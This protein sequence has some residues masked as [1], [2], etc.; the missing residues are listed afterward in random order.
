LKIK[1]KKRDKQNPAEPSGPPSFEELFKATGGARLGMRARADQQ[2]K[3]I[4]TEQIDPSITGNNIPEITLLNVEI[5][6]NNLEII[7]KEKI[8][9]VEMNCSKKRSLNIMEP[10]SDDLINI[11]QNDCIVS[12]EKAEKKKRKKEKKSKIY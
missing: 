6:A 5:K 10:S 3:W 4:R 9:K 1:R 12:E 2:G 11:N 8:E 7:N